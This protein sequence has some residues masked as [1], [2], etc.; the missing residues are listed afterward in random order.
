M[1]PELEHICDLSVEVGRPHE[2][3]ACAKGTRRIIPIVGGSAHGSRLNGRILG[4]GVPTLDIYGRLPPRQAILNLRNG[5]GHIF[6]VV[7][8][9]CESSAP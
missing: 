3:G 8:E 4:V 6:G 2:M 1:T 5:L 9:R 7:M